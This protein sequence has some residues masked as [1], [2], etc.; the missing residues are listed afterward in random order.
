[1][2]CIDAEDSGDDSAAGPRGGKRARRQGPTTLA[3]RPL[4]RQPQPVAGAAAA[5]ALGGACRRAAAPLELRQGAQSARCRVLPVLSALTLI[6]RHCGTGSAGGGSGSGSPVSGGR[7]R[8]PGAGERALVRGHLAVLLA[9]AVAATGSVPSAARGAAARSREGGPPAYTAAAQV[10]RALPTAAHEASLGMGSVRCIASAVEAFLALQRAAG[11]EDSGMQTRLGQ[12]TRQLLAAGGEGPMSAGSASSGDDLTPVKA[13]LPS[14]Q[15]Q[16]QR[17]QR[18]RAAVPSWLRRSADAGGPAT[19]PAPGVRALPA[20][21]EAA[22]AAPGGT[23][24]AAGWAAGAAAPKPDPSDRRQPRDQRSPAAEAAAEAPAPA[25]PT[26]ASS[27][28]AVPSSPAPAAPAR[29]R[30][31]PSELLRST[32]ARRRADASA[33]SPASSPASSWRSHSVDPPAGA[34]RL[35]ADSHPSKPPALPVVDEQVPQ[36]PAEP[37]SAEPLPAESQKAELPKAEL[38]KAELPKAELPKADRTQAAAREAAPAR[39]QPGDASAKPAHMADAEAPST[40]SRRVRTMAPWSQ[41]EPGPQQATHAQ[42]AQCAPAAAAAPPP[43]PAGSGSPSAFSEGHVAPQA[44]AA[45]ADAAPPALPDAQSAPAQPLADPPAVAP[46]PQR[47]W[48][49]ASRL[50]T[51][52]SGPGRK[53]DTPPSAR[54][55]SLRRD[56]FSPLSGRRTPTVTYARRKRRR[57]PDATG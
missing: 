28:P 23:R 4:A 11:L 30:R 37:H 17:Q 52:T 57:D 45:V 29:P 14:P 34:A 22:A 38:P 6:F 21:R 42:P 46:P 32:L 56:L 50:L 36:R 10:R 40:T 27:P 41:A 39:P 15:R 7:G 48:P 5:W 55:D 26:G 33:S 44:A 25:L 2:L 3:S 49:R 9:A 24:S 16:D 47:A 20:Q 53:A 43:A 18:S 8:G 51:P 19:A 31:S 54:S 12:V 35:F 1:M 13:S